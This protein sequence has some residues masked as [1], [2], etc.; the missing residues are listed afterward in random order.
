MSSSEIFNSI[1]VSEDLITAGQPTAEQL[2][3]VAQEGFKTVINLATS[4]PPYSLEGEAG[5]VQAL[6]MNY[7]HIP[8]VWDNPQESDY[9]AF[10]RVMSDLPAGR[11]LIHCAANFR[12]T[13]FY[14][15]YAQQHL[16]WSKDEAE[17][18]R[19]QIWAGSDYP[20]WRAFIARMTDRIAS[21]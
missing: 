17:K 1:K 20:I 11:T 13:A 7:F 15:L 5:L 8:V 9:Q 16:G 14:S 4:N 3:S 2:R 19:A 10:E 21:G 18:F 12:V 6:G